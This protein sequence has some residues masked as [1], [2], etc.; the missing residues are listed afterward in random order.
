M[1]YDL[2]IVVD[3]GDGYKTTVFDRNITYNLRNMLVE[4]GLPDS[5]HSLNGKTCRESQDIL[6]TVWHELRT[7]PYYYKRFDSPNGW[8]LQKNLLPWIRDLYL[9]SRQHPRGVI[10]VS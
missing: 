6:Y 7:R 9:K 5:L 2:V 1:S 10:R 3:H 8:G 4:A